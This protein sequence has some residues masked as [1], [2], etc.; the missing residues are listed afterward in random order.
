VIKE[1]I[2]Q[3]AKS[4]GIEKIGFCEGAVVA[5]FPYYVAQ[6]DGNL[7][8][9]ARSVDYHIV[10]EEKLRV[11]AKLLEE[12]GAN[13]AEVHVDKGKHDDRRAAYEAGLGFYGMNGM[14][15]CR[16]YGSYFFIGQILHDLDI[17]ADET[18]TEECLMCGRCE[19][20]CPGNA[21]RSGKVEEEKCLSY[22]TQKRGEL[23]QD[24]VRLMK[25]HGTCWGCDVCQRVC[26]HNRGLKTTAI[27]EFLDS[28]IAK[29]KAEDIEGLS[30]KEFK[31]RYGGYAFSW[32]G[33]SVLLRN[34][35]AYEEE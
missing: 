22:I 7:S 4:L 28:R 9:Y 18:L 15:I 3:R 25:K 34:L 21:L 32:R 30:N 31:K 14:L 6:E 24:D 19:R 2:R 27:P 1:K 13:F 8:L 33:K 35:R 5:L 26:P 10:A 17:E 23:T 20:E 11:L 12:D 16:E 29:L